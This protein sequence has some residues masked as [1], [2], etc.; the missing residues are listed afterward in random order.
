MANDAIP[1]SSSSSEAAAEEEEK[2]KKRRSGRGGGGGGV[3]SRVWKGIFGAGHDLE[4]ELRRLSVA[5]ASA[6]ARIKRRAQATRAMRTNLVVVSIAL[7]VLRFDLILAELVLI[8]SLEFIKLISN[9]GFDEVARLSLCIEM[10]LIFG[11]CLIFSNH[12]R[13]DCN[14]SGSLNHKLQ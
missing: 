3:V 6:H 12:I 13:F 14:N 2:K 10:S 4:K 9:L 8:R 5:E 7:E 11:S 1:S